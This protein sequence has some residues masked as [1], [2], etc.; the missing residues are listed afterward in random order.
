MRIEV[1][2]RG[3]VSSICAGLPG[4]RRATPQKAGII[5]QIAVCAEGNAAAMSLMSRRLSPRGR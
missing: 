1:A 4:R 5:G 2:V 3:P